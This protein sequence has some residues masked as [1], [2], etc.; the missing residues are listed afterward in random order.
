MSLA[1]LPSLLL[2]FACW[3]GFFW[4]AREG[5]FR[6]LLPRD[7]RMAFVL[8]C[9]GW[10]TALAGITEL[11]GWWRRLNLSGVLTLWLCVDVVVWGCALRLS[12]GTFG[13]GTPWRVRLHL[14][15]K[16][17]WR[18][19]LHLFRESPMQ[20][21]LVVG[22]ALFLGGVALLTPTTNWDSL[23]YH[24]PRVLHWIQQQSLAHYPTSLESQLQMAPWAA[25]VQLQ[26]CLI[27]GLDQMVNLPQWFAL[28]GCLIVGTLITRQLLGPADQAS[29]R[30]EAWAALLLVTLP[31][32]IVESLT[33]QT[34]Y[35]T[36]FWL[37][38][39]VSLILALRQDRRNAWCWLGAGC[40][41]GL[42]L[43]TKVTTIFYAA[44]L[45]AALAVLAFRSLPPLTA[46]RN[47]C[48]LGAVVGLLNAPHA[49]R[50]YQLY[51]SPAGSSFY[52]ESARNR[53]VSPGSAA[54]NV[55]RNLALHTGTGVRILTTGL[56]RALNRLHVLTGR[57]LNDPEASFGLGRFEFYDRLVI[58]D[59]YAGS[60][61]HLALVACALGVCLRRPRARW[62]PL[63][64]AGLVLGGLLLICV[65]LRWQRWNCRLH[66]PG[67]ALL[68]PFVAAALGPRLR[69]WGAGLISLGLAVFAGV[70]VANN[71]SRPV[72]NP[73]FRKMPRVQ[74][75]LAVHAPQLH[76]E[77]VQVVQE[78][79]RH[80][81]RNVGLKL[82]IDDPEY[83]LWLL[84]LGH[85]LSGRIDH[86]AVQN[87]SGRIPIPVQP[88]VVVS[89]FEGPLPAPLNDRY[90]ASTAIGSYTLH[91]STDL[92][93]RRLNLKRDTGE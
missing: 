30:I 22:F 19:L 56:N 10:G 50:N 42:G 16:T 71:I 17:D 87:A 35:V 93:E 48:A 88:D 86:V 78:V 57:D 85:G 63:L 73:A 39:W 70:V 46:V 79:S 55:I 84:F 6:G 3:L 8:A 43:L 45:F 32:G 33:P 51:G 66:L 7:W 69:P 61:Y 14:P 24:L 80:G 76:A 2:V 9:L 72:F 23:T 36:A 47:L 31:T 41:L 1:S 49:L 34:D 52:Q 53:S 75:M 12:R 92:S 60:P 21:S 54:S 20:L 26:L 62:L 38:C 13:R 44:P 65:V 82:G 40:A 90:P 83:P 89:V 37:F 11:A 28:G 77:M 15:D 4:M 18:A 29:C 74:Q 68:M 81:G 27:G 58:F 67:L 25:Y 64:Y 59:S 5:G 91:W